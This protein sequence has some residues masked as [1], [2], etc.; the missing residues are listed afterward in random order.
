M[1]GHLTLPVSLQG[2]RSEAPYRVQLS[3]AA[4]FIHSFLINLSCCQGEITHLQINF[5]Q[6]RWSLSIYLASLLSYTA[7]DCTTG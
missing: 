5:P 2:A 6:L 3:L 1:Q 7:I 4:V